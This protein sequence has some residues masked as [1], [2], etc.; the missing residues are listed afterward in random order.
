MSILKVNTIQDKGGNTLLSSDGAGTLSGGLASNTP[1]FLAYLGSNQVFS[2]G[3]S[4]KIQL[5]TVS[6][7]TDSGFDNTTNYRYTIP[8]GKAGKYIFNLSGRTDVAIGTYSY[9]NIRVNGSNNFRSFQGTVKP[10]A[11]GSTYMVASVMV[12][13][14][15][16]DYVELYMYQNSGSDQLAYAN[17][18]SLSGF[19]IIGA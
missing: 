4:T 9:I 10:N 6:W 13:M 17:Y 1:S 18:C 5:N 8:S 15:V 12:D 2:S 14:A 7:D 16:G 3:T 19:R 11:T